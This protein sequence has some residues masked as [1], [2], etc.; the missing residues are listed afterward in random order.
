MKRITMKRAIEIL[1]PARKAR[2]KDLLDYVEQI[3]EAR[4]MGV[5]ALK[6]ARRILLRLHGAGG[7]DAQD[8]YSKGWDAAITEAIGIVES[9]TG[10]RLEEVLDQD[11]K[12]SRTDKKLRVANL[13]ADDIV[14]VVRC[15]HC[16]WRGKHPELG[17]CVRG[18]AVFDEN[19]F[20]NY[21][22]RK[23]EASK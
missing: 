15:K 10:I 14:P 21:G 19:G 20:C 6:A 18:M 8:D 5:E 22:E 9:E 17:R 4:R 12:N 23:D 1:D 13:N 11:I 7:C 2:Y 3:E 16:R